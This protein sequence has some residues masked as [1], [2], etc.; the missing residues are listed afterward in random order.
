MQVKALQK[1]TD[2]QAAPQAAARVA[3]SDAVK[4]AEFQS[5][6][7]L[8]NGGRTPPGPTPGGPSPASRPRLAA[9]RTR[10]QPGRA[11]ASGP[12]STRA[13]SPR[14]QP[15]RRVCLLTPVQGGGASS[16]AK[17]GRSASSRA[18]SESNTGP[19]R[20][21]KASDRPRLAR[22]C[23]RGGTGS[24]QRR[25]FFRNAER[26]KP[27]GGGV[28]RASPECEALAECEQDVGH[29]SKDLP[30]RESERVSALF[31]IARRAMRF[32]PG[33]RRKPSGGGV[34]AAGA[35]VLVGSLAN[36]VTGR[37]A[38]SRGCRARI[39]LHPKHLLTEG[40]ECEG[41]VVK[42]VAALRPR[43]LSRKRQ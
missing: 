28:R 24:F 33:G 21:C 11:G 38:G 6:S 1:E 12:A 25:A 43:P 3:S 9:A 20:K 19:F 15:V 40:R 17:S 39:C 32:T 14:A 29:K 10:P 37:A 13:S 35:A 42:N 5:R 34:G 22:P 31:P 2:T 7:H 30:L 36:P 8:N 41:A 16:G 26:S 27:P 4:G 18:G 23:F